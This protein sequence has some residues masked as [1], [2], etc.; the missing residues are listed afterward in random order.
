MSGT[1]CRANNTHTHTLYANYT[2]Q[3]YRWWIGPVERTRRPPPPPV[4]VDQTTIVWW[5][6]RL[7][8]A[9]DDDGGWWWLMPW[10]TLDVQKQHSN[11]VGRSESVGFSFFWR[12]ACSMA[13]CRRSSAT[14]CSAPRGVGHRVC[15]RHCVHRSRIGT[16]GHGLGVVGVLGWFCGGGCGGRKG[17]FYGEGGKRNGI[18]VRFRVLVSSHVGGQQNV[19]VI[20]VLIIETK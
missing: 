14:S 20:Y 5:P 18:G 8:T 11:S 15:R 10:L 9:A 1:K 17:W 6:R 12:A 2:L 19:Y 3:V 13:I 16:F 4:R 7:L